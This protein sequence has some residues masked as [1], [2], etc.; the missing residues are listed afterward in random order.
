MYICNLF[1]ANMM[2]KRD[3][4]WRIFTVLFLSRQEN[5]VVLLRIL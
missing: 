2:P 4:R 1:Y 3:D 5:E